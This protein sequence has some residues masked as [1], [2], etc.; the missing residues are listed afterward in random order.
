V[1]LFFYRWAGSAVEA[2]A[3]GVLIASKP[4]A[5]V[6]STAQSYRVGGVYRWYFSGEF[7][8]VSLS[9]A[10][11]S[12]SWICAQNAAARELL[13]AVGPVETILDHF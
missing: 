4:L 9:I 1:A 5:S 2:Y 3:D 11:R 7:D 13:I 12:A 6:K 8:E 10:A